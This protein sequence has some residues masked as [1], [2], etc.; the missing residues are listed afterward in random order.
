MGAERPATAD[1]EYAGEVLWSATLTVQLLQGATVG[2]GPAAPCASALSEDEF[3]YLGR[4]HRVKLVSRTSSLLSFDLGGTIP[5]TLYR[6]AT[7]YVD[8]TPFPLSNAERASN[9]IA[10][11]RVFWN[12]SISWTQGDTVELRLERG[13]WFVGVEF[14][15][16]DTSTASDGLVELQVSEDGTATFQVRLTQAPTANVTVGLDR[17]FTPCAGCGQTYHGNR[18]AATLSKQSLTFTP[19][20]YSTG[21]MV[22]VTGVADTDSVHDHVNILASPVTIA[23]SASDGDP[24]RTPERFAGMWVTITDGTDTGTQHGGL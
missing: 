20:N 18:D 24:Y 19:S 22:T 8:G 2:C 10:N 13:P 5:D 7:L 21:Q 1:H 15:G 9:S 4:S 6:H 3:T 12:S 11:D 23:S 14:F 16:G 17:N